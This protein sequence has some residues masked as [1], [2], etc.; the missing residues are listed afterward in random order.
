MAG[1]LPDDVVAALARA[2]AGY[3]PIAAFADWLPPHLSHTGWDDARREVQHLRAN[4]SDSVVSDLLKR[5]L[6]GAAVDTGAIEG[7]YRAD[8]GFTW[9]VATEAISMTEAERDGGEAFA[10]NFAAQLEAFEYVVDVAVRQD[11][12]TESL[13]RQM[14]E[15]TCRG[16]ATYEV[17][18]AVGWQAQ[19]LP[20]GS[21]KVHPN[22]PHLPS[23]EFRPFA[24]V[25]EVAAEMARL[26]AEL[27]SDQ[28]LGAHPTEQAAYAHHALT[29]IH[30]FADG[31]GRVARLLASVWLV[32]GASIPL[33]IRTDDRA[34]YIEGLVGADA[35]RIEP[36]ISLISDVSLGLLRDSALA[37]Q[38]GRL[39]S[40]AS[41][42]SILESARQGA[43]ALLRSIAEQR[44]GGVDVRAGDRLGAVAL[45]GDIEVSKA[46][47]VVLLPAGHG[48]RWAA[49]GIDWAAGDDGRFVAVSGPVGPDPLGH[50][51]QIRV[52]FSERELIPK[53]RS[54]ARGRIEQ[55]VSALIDVS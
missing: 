19:P 17:M 2:D 55:F 13:L 27:R 5:H 30:P 29:H 54:G 8:A 53:V 10:R 34:D 32:R 16:Q 11:P 24:P 23:G 22:S 6:R 43:D 48:T 45:P 35:G 7:L 26:V 50:L 37:L 28:F 21:Y 44:L 38:E 9:S 52:R 14:H 40:E 46:S 1:A 41:R 18:T 39:R 51:R 4:V 36:W 25:A 20:L 47:G 31:N 3:Q 15:I 12:V 33:W 42:R 49:I